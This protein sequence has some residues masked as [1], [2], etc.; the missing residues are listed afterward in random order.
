MVRGGKTPH[1]PDRKPAIASL[2]TGIPKPNYESDLQMEAR[3][4]AESG[5]G[6]VDA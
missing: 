3:G 2:K 5:P 4:T 1:C 6:R